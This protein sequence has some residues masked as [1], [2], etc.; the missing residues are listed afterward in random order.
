MVL[1]G[2][3]YD[4]EGTRVSAGIVQGQDR[5][6]MVGQLSRPSGVVGVL[7]V[8][9]LA[10]DTDRLQPFQGVEHSLSVGG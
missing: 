3:A 7:H 8:L 2:G 4:D 10:V 1:E 6:E 9:S 5:P